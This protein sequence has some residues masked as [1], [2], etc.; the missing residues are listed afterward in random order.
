MNLCDGKNPGFW[1]GEHVL[2]APIVHEG[3]GCPLC[4]ALTTLGTVQSELAS[5]QE[6]LV[7]AQEEQA[8]RDLS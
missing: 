4:E 7:A 6:Q 1:H 8:D 2:H 5:V 3:D